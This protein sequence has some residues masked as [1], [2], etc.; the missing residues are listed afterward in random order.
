MDIAKPQTQAW[1]DRYWTS[2]DGLKLH[3]RDYDGPADRPPLLMLHGL[4]RNARDFENVAER[5]AGDWRVLAVDFRGRG[6]SEWDSDSSH[7][8]PPIYAADVL[9]L[10]DELGI[11]QAVFM[12]TSLG[13]LV[14]MIIATVAPQRIAG[15][16]LNDVGPEL[17]FSGIDRIKSYVGKQVL[18]RDWDDAADRLQ[19][20]AGDVYPAYDHAAWVR[21]AKRACRQTEGGVEF[22]YDMRIAE[23]FEAGNTG[24]I[25]DAWPYYRALGDR[26]VL[27]LR[28]E[29]SDL[30][31]G[32][33]ADR[34]AKEIL[35]VEVVTVK[36]VGH[37]P[38]L[39]E[40]EAVAAIDRL[41]ERVLKR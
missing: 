21:F 4:T 38:D 39:D 3:Y 8:H 15:A 22:D 31:P 10:L 33:A 1:A 19:Q 29:H 17:D 13:G 23:P 12:G 30:L 11:E 36:G 24:E 41:L 40:P 25:K 35:D 18:F 2:C 34:M 16:L 9:Q 5:Y 28:G 6:M 14:T 20:R 26:P 27:V 7:Y 32:P 37:A